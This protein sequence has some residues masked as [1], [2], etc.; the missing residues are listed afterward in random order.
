MSLSWC[1][2]Y[3]CGSC[4]KK[5]LGIAKDARRV[6]ILCSRVDISFRLL[7]GTSRFKDLHEIVSKL[8]AKLDGEVGP[9]SDVSAKMARGIVSRLS[10]A[11]D[12]QTLCTLAIEKADEWVATVSGTNR[13]C[14]G[15]S[16]CLYLLIVALY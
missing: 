6:D 2:I 13:N 3:I 15:M 1:K 14:I 8:K 11:S 5:Q 7:D 9:V 10:I 12:V 4:W 16:K